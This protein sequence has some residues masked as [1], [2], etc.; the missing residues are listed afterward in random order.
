[1]NTWFK[2]FYTFFPVQLFILH[3]RK[4]QV[5]LLFWYV[6]FSCINSSFL[7]SY[8]ADALFF[9]P[10]Y[11]NKVG[12]LGAFIVGIALGV[13]FM[14]W[15]ITTFILH[16]R[17]FKFLAT[18]TNPFLKYC[19][20]NSILPGL[21]LIFYFIKLYKYDD[22]RELMAFNEIML[23][24]IGI[25]A[26]GA[27]LVLLSFVYFFGADKTISKRVAAIVSNP[28]QFKKIFL[29]KKLGMDFFALP[30]NYYITGRLKLKKT[31]S[32][33]HYRD[34][35]IESIFKR[36][37][38]AAIVSILLAFLFLILVGFFLDKPFF[39]MPAAASVFIF[40]SLMIALIGALAY[41]LQSWSLPAAILL[42][43]FFNFL[44]EKGYLDPRNKA[45]GLEYPNNDLRPKY[46]P[47]SLN[48]ICS[49]DILQK[50]KEQMI[51]VL[52]KWKTRQ[53]S[54]KPLMIFINVSGGGLRSSAFTMHA[55]Q[56]LDSMLQGKLMKKTFLI[57]GA[58]GGMLAATYYRELYRRKIHGASI[59]L[60]SPQYLNNITGDLLN[61]VFSSMMARDLMASSLKFSVGNNKYIKDRG[62]AF[63]KKLSENTN[64]I[65]N[66]QLKNIQKDEA[67]ATVPL[68]LFNA[69]VK[70]DGKK[71]ILSTLPMSFMMKPVALQK[72]TS[73]SPD[74]VDFAAL[75]KNQQPMNLRLLSAL[76]MNATFPYV[77]P[78]V[79][80]PTNPV[81]DVMDAGLRDNFGQEA[82]LRFLDNFKNWVEEN[83]SG[84]LIIQIRDRNTSNWMP[85]FEPRTATDVLVSPA[86]ML[87]NNWFR[88]QDYYQDTDFA[89][90]KNSFGTMLKKVMVMYIPQKP[91]KK[92]ALNFH[93]TAR[94]KRDIIESFDSP[95]TLHAVKEIIELLN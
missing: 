46:D 13:F 16:S 19:L 21:F 70:G 68:L 32:V 38:L 20:N 28:D 48:A 9:A 62:Y 54:A 5:L 14:S 25:L 81:I 8:G 69:V 45:Y 89:Y 26:G 3:F 52:N 49:A 43:L 78:N 93:L 7:K 27:T 61:S 76:R 73:I 75:F 82:T 44:F 53:D 94:E 29:G 34:D 64:D 51:S 80:L 42:L 71:M 47:G 30:V 23:L 36:H 2:N 67:D 84:V 41:F 86:T 40:F 91:D 17:R 50:D 15:H 11:L 31:R 57:S 12:I 90:F 55:M 60:S 83:T 72:D 37:H 58:S 6:L 35:F 85:P 18:T 74:A 77:L 59:H 33:S 56:K 63:E 10:E 66:V 95:N 65:L 92:V 24:M 88:M 39:E 87:Q 22:Y 79:W 4:Y 1:M